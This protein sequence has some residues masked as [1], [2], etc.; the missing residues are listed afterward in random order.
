VILA[1]LIAVGVTLPVPRSPWPA[2]QGWT[3]DG[4]RGTGNAFHDVHLTHTRMVVEGR[5]IACRVRLF[6][7]DLEKA[8]EQFAGRPDLH[9]TPEARADSLFAAYFGRTVTLEAD[10]RPV[11]LQ[12]SG[13]GTERDPSSQDIVWYVLEGESEAPIVRLGILNGLMFERFRDQQNLV[14]LL[15]EPGGIRKTLYFV[16]TEPREQVVSF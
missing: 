1:L 7:D 11:S 5:T 4:R 9:L 6:K 2:V 3:G 14:Q 13:S 16:T 12:V 15:R 10:G 8:L